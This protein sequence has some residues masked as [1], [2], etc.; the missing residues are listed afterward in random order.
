MVVE[1]A[2]LIISAGKERDFEAAVNSAKSALTSA[3]GCRSVTLMRCVEQPE[4]Y[5]LAI[6]WDTIENHMVDFK[7]SP[8]AAAFGAAIKPFI[9][10]KQPMLHFAPVG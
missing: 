9:A 10:D 3:K 7:N 6:E 8:S 4:I 5:R 2:T 1:H